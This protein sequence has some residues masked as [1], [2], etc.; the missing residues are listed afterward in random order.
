VLDQ[1]L[2]D[3]VEKA[4]L[5][6]GIVNPSGDEEVCDAAQCLDAARGAAFELI[7]PISILEYRP[8]A[9][10]SPVGKEN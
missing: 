9:V 3:I 4:D 5:L 7:V 6:V 10:S 2:K 8:A 1:A